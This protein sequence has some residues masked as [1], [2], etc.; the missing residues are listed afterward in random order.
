[1]DYTIFVIN[2]SSS[3]WDNYKDDNRFT[4]W[5]G[6]N[7]KEDL[8]LDFVNDKYH[9]Y[10]NCNDDLRMNIA[11]CSESHLSCIKHIYENK[12][13]NAIIIE[14]DTIVDFEKLSSLK[15]LNKVV[16]LGG[17]FHP[18]KLK[19]KNKFEKPVFDKDLSV[20]TI[21]TESFLISGAFG[22]LIPHWNLASDLLEQNGK[23]RRAIDVEFKNLQKKGIWN[24][25]VYPPIVK[26]DMKTAMTGF[27]YNDKR[28]KLKD[29]LEFY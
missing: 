29:D 8:S 11:G 19:D 20:R 23:K 3:R 10:W 25:F 13:D 18:V 27:T 17:D 4:R 7:G 2:I 5:V 28:Y 9:F 22:Y 1:M 6:C 24:Q 14:D 12:I 15:Q 26:L 21:D 16:Y